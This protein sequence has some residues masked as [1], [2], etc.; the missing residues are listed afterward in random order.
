MSLEGPNQHIL[1]LAEL[2]LSDMEVA[3][4]AR[5]KKLSGNGEASEGNTGG[6]KTVGGKTMV[7][8]GGKKKRR[9]ARKETYIFYIY[10][11]IR[12]ISD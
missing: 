10:T 6:S 5:G 1:G 7:V 3:P 12:R 9:K 2:Q 11:I 4:T 8:P